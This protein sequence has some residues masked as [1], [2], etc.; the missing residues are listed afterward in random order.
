MA[1]VKL[2]YYPE[3]DSL[4]IELLEK[5]G[6]KTLEIRAGLNADIDG[7]DQV[8]GFDIDHL[9]EFVAN[10][11]PSESQSWG[12]L[13]RL[14]ADPGQAGAMEIFRP[15]TYAFE[16]AVMTPG[17]Q[18]QLRALSGFQSPDASSVRLVSLTLDDPAP[19]IGTE[20]DA[21]ASL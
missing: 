8:V 19:L 12:Q 13:T 20:H 5:P 18:H 17:V 15:Y 1:R 9:S 16:N 2:H 11:P 7:N 4:Y 21:V 3:T 14:P 6:V 10:N